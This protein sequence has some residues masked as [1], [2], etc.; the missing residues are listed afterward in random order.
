MLV[1][2]Q[3]VHFAVPE[4]SKLRGS[5]SF[6]SWPWPSAAH[7]CW[8][9]SGAPEVK[10]RRRLAQTPRHARHPGLGD[11]FAQ[12]SLAL[13]LGLQLLGAPLRCF[14]T[15]RL[16]DWAT[17]LSLGFVAK[18]LMQAGD[19]GAAALRCSRASAQRRPCSTAWERCTA[20]WRLAWCRHS[21]SGLSEP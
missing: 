19:S 21:L 6:P 11:A 15:W 5:S 13:D 16:G 9:C 8:R 12:L 18:L 10:D 20:A 14:P 4:G 17:G 1:S 7:L 3:S 2:L